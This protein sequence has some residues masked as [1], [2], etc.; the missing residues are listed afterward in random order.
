MKNTQSKKI[1]G[2]SGFTTAMLLAIQY[3][4]AQ[5]IYT[6]IADAKVNPANSY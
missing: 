2:Y 1:S 3:S 4:N 5:L 6:D